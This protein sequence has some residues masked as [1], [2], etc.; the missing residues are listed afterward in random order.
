MKI[1]KFSARFISI[2]GLA[3]VL[4]AS[5]VF[6]N[7]SMPAK[8][9][10]EPKIEVIQ[11]SAQ[12]RKQD[13][14]EV[15]ISITALSA[16]AIERLA[17]SDNVEI[18]QQV[19]NLQLTSF[20]PN[21]ALFNL[22]GV[23]QNSFTDNLESPVAVYADDAYIASLNAV[24]GLLF[25]AKR[26]EVLRGPQGTLFGR[27]ATGG[28]IHYVSNDASEAVFNGYLK[29][30]KARFDRTFIE[31]AVGGS[32]NETIRARLA[33]RQEKADGYI[34]SASTDIR[35]IGGA[36]AQAA[37]LSLQAEVFDNVLLD[38]SHVY[39][40]DQD[41]PTGG[42]AFLPWTEKEIANT[43]LPPE[44][45]D[46]TQNVIL[47]GEAPPN[48]MTIEDFTKLVFF[49]TEDGFTPVD[50][51]GLTLYQG[52][53]A[54]PHKHFSNIN[55]FLNRKVQNST[56]KLTIDLADEVE[57]ISISNLQF[58]DKIYLEDGDGIAAPII[59][60]QTETDYQQWSQELRLSGIGASA[61]WQLG[62]Y[63]LDM[64]QEG[65]ITTIGNPVIRLATTLKN[66]GL[67]AD[68]YDPLIGSPQATQ[69]YRTDSENFSVFAQYEY[70]LT[71][72]LVIIAGLRWSEDD[73]SLHYRRGFEDKSADIAL[74]EQVSVNPDS[75]N[76]AVID[77][78]DYSARLQL[79]WQLNNEI[80]NFVSYNRGIKV[81]NWA[82]SAG[83]PVENMQHKPE[84]LHAYEMGS[85]ALLQDKSLQ[86]N[87]TAFY[88]DYRDYQAFSMSG[89]APQI[90]NSDATAYGGEIELS[91][92]P[93]IHIFAQLGLSFMQSE[94]ENVS[95]VDEWISPVA[96]T[97]IDFPLDVLTNRELPNAPDYSVNYLFNYVWPVT[98]TIVSGELS[99]QLDGVYYDDQYLEVSNG[100]GAYQKAYGVNNAH[101]AYTTAN[102]QVQLMLWV[103]NLTNETYKQYNLDLGMLGSTAYYAPPRTYGVSL[104]FSFE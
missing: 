14:Q 68:N 74:I 55:G 93:N 43:Y 78:Q 57:L 101:L 63:W 34:K 53:H 49:N 79:N 84:T 50:S 87:A 3:P 86:L 8:F 62:S 72:D 76:I 80:L 38:F 9:D 27:N 51:A 32:L 71:S 48:Q 18:T 41:V 29:A 10:A 37:R 35:A 99:M 21:L 97:V 103:K 47:E 1:R 70:L 33:F 69:D 77:Y 39:A 64:Q 22:R 44:L 89:L 31:S 11:V 52:D 25:D 95:A 88:Y 19:P 30:G 82:F 66:E 7:E 6:A 46:F 90:D 4:F 94:V 98:S 83:V 100:G 28:M 24:S 12:K 102:T 59:A 92:Q 13:N 42:Y 96:N 26:V 20:S 104:K 5:A 58:L 67:L 73:K 45:V 2:L 36:D 16:K 15:G 61:R 85:K 54:M 65:R 23:S 56:A 40:K 81:G 91:W 17:I 60:F 75:S